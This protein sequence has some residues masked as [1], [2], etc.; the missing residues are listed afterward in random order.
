MLPKI[1]AKFGVPNKII[2]LLKVS[3]ANFVLKFTVDD[4][5]QSLDCIIGV[6]QGDILGP[7][8]FTFFTAAVMITWKASYNT[9]LCNADAMLTGHSYL[10]Y[11]E[12][13]P[14]LESEY[15]D[16]RYIS[17]LCKCF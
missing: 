12:S 3:H 8:S 17:I 13:F 11:G 9:P 14:V 7:I 5:T 2:S 4:V 16:D 1:L 15:A 10:D 6:K